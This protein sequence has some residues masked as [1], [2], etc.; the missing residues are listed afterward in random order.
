M[1]NIQKQE[2]QQMLRERYPYFGDDVCE[3]LAEEVLRLERV[4]LLKAPVREWLNQYTEFTDVTISTLDGES[5]WSLVE[6]AVELDEDDPDIPVAA[7]LFNL[8]EE[9][10]VI[11][12]AIFPICGEMCAADYRLFQENSPQLL[13]LILDEQTEEW[14]FV[15]ENS[16]PEWMQEYQIW[17]PL[18][19]F[20]SL[21]P[22]LVM[23]HELGTAIQQEED[24]VWYVVPPESEDG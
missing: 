2:V 8:Y 11:F 24:G 6:I 23:D 4:E 5:S 21:A 18:L 14:T 7:L 19:S 22:L 16:K 20:P 9:A 3:W 15:A 17:L 10:P 12:S 1:S 13:G